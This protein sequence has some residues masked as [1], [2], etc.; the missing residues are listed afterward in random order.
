MSDKRIRQ[1]AVEIPVSSESPETKWISMVYAIGNVKKLPINGNLE[2]RTICNIVENT[3]C[4]S[5]YISNENVSQIW[6][7][8]PKSN[9][10][11]VEYIID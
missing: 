2:K 7:D 8:I 4:Y 5:I 11:R 9:K 6:I 1:L 10:V 3:D